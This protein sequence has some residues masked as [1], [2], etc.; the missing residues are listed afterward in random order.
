MEKPEDYT[1][2]IAHYDNIGWF[3][4]SLFLIFFGTLLLTFGNWTED[5][6]ILNRDLIGMIIIFTMVFGYIVSRLFIK[7]QKETKMNILEKRDDFD[8]GNF[9]GNPSILIYLIFMLFVQIILT[10]LLARV[11]DFNV[12]IS[13]IG[14]IIIIPLVICLEECYKKENPLSKFI[15]KG[16]RKLFPRF[17]KK[18]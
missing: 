6:S 13:I 2:L 5:S 7:S 14:T 3:I 18:Y 17:S 11:F 1:T 4:T 10:I 9:L 15:K 16:V 12:I 8:I